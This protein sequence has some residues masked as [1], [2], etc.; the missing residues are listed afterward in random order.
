MTEKTYRSIFI[1]DV[2]L[3]TR[4]CKAEALNNFL[5]HNTCE[6]LYLVGDIIDAWKIQQNRWRWK[7]S[8]TN[9][10]R[11]V[12]GHAKRGT[13]VIYV[14]GNHDEFLRP[15]I[16]LGIGFGLIEVVNQAEHIGIDG[17]HYLVTHGDLFDGITRLA[18]WLAFLGDKLYDFVLNFA[19]LKHVR[20]EKNVIS[21]LQMLQTNAADVLK[22]LKWLVA[23]K[24]DFTFFN[25]ST[26]KAANPV[27]VLGA[28]KQ[29]MENLIFSFNEEFNSQIKFISSR[30]ANVA[31]SDGSLFHSY[32]NR[33]DNKDLLPVPGATKRF[34][35]SLEEAGTI[36][37][38]SAFCGENNQIYIPKLH[39]DSDLQLL[40][41]V[42]EKAIHFFGFKA[43]RYYSEVEAVANLKSDLQNGNYPL[44]V[45]MLDTI[46]EK[47][48]EEFENDDEIPVECNFKLLAKI[49]FVN[50]SIDIFTVFAELE[51]YNS[52]IS[53]IDKSD[54]LMQI[55][56]K[57][58]F[59]FQHKYSA[60][61]LDNR[62]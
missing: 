42:A 7:Q 62:R 57:G 14:A 16:P 4:D 36:C 26:D 13:R 48:F 46:G 27:N 58:T 12:M 47:D 3:G 19:A 1:S 8:H 11:R 9:V 28:S 5:K 43:K 37:M 23:K 22:C 49:G 33:L 34:F 18:P 59:N 41:K 55:I 30:F 29:I 10:I 6:T 20:S 38:L 2:H 44:L 52:Q 51:K 53:V 31:A 39:K 60:L 17:N 35:I 24:N 25:V 56:R 45:T 15:L 61:S 40:D 21:I 32:I 54:D 50:R